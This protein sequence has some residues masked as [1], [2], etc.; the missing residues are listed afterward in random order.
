VELMT[1]KAAELVAGTIGYPSK[2]P[3]TSYGIP[4]QACI[5]GSKLREIEGS[6]CSKC[7]AFNRGNY[8]Y[9]SVKMSQEKRLSGIASDLW[10]E[11]MITLLVK[12]HSYGAKKTPK[13]PL[14]PF[15][16]WHD[17]GDIQSRDHL[18]K[19]CAVARA[20]PWLKHWLPTREAM[21]VKAFVRDGG[22]IPQNLIIRVSATMV[23]G[24]APTSWPHTS[25]VHDKTQGIGQSCVAPLQ[26]N[27]C[28]DCRAC[29]DKNIPN[30]TYHVH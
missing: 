30:I 10:V 25:T 11:A 28:G 7:Y 22:T 9:E 8:I 16:R 29:W 5:V 6:T 18:A 4:A 3:G 14:P 20:T 2:M 21:I 23:D 1:K 13:N 15:H 24:N 12:A 19:I 17:S 27:K 26:D